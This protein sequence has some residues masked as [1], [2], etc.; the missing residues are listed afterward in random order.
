MNC[1]KWLEDTKSKVLEVAEESF[2]SASL[3][4]AFPAGTRT[5]IVR[6]IDRNIKVV[7]SCTEEI[8]LYSVDV[9]FTPVING[10]D[11]AEIY[12]AISEA[13]ENK[14]STIERD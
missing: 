9:L 10:P 5:I 4:S 8:A 13:L 7:L 2:T 12:K 14:T 1:E 11:K 6:N 3:L